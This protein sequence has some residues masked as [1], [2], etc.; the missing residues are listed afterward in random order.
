MSGLFRSSVCA[1]SGATTAPAETEPKRAWTYGH[2]LWL[3][4][5][6]GIETQQ[7]AAHPFN[8]LLLLRWARVC[9][10]AGFTPSQQRCGRMCR[11]VDWMSLTAGDWTR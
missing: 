6:H 9:A 7:P 11:G 8:P 5:P 4:R 3:A 1:R 2:V 10:P